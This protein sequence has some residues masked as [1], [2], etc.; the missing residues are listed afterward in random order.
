MTGKLGKHATSLV[1]VLAACGLG[2]YAWRDRATVS[3]DERARRERNVFPAWRR[4]DLSRITLSHD[5]EEVVLVRALAGD[6]MWRMT[7]PRDGE[8][9]AALVDRFL[10]TLEFATILRK[11]SGPVP[12]FDSP[13]ARGT[14]E[15]GAVKYEFALGSAAST[16]EG[17]AYFRMNGDSPVVIGKELAVDLMKGADAF[18]T[19]TLVPYLSLALARLEVRGRVTSFAVERKGNERGFVLPSRSLR[20]SRERLDKVWRA[21]AEMRAE[22]FVSDADADA[23]TK[24]P[25]LSITMT[26]KDGRPNGELLVGGACPGQPNDVVVVQRAPTKTAGCAPKGI[27]EGLSVTEGWLL[28]TRLFALRDDEIEQARL[29]SSPTGAVLD[30]ARKGTGFRELAPE[31]RDLSEGE[32]DAASTLIKDLA[33]AEGEVIGRDASNALGHGIT[34]RV[35]VTHAE[36]GEEEVIEVGLAADEGGFFVRRRADGAVIRVS[37]ETAR[38]LLPRANALRP[39]ALFSEPLAGKPVRA[40]ETRCRGLAQRVSRDGDAFRLEVDGAPLAADSG[41]ILDAI[42]ALSR[43]RADAWVADADDGT[44][45]FDLDPCFFRATFAGSGSDGGGGAAATRTAG[46][47]F[48]ADTIT[49]TYARLDG[50]RAVFVAPQG[51]RAPLTSPFIDRHRLVVDPYSLL[52]IDVTRKGV[53]RT[54]DPHAKDDAGILLG[55]DAAGIL[56]ETVHMGPPRRGEGFEDAV[57]I[58]LRLASDGGKASIRFSLGVA[59]QRGGRP[60]RLLRIPGVDA[61]LAAPAGPDD[62]LARLLGRP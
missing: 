47:T 50:D 16:P 24:D 46:V 31:Q 38:K 8:V 41:M 27:L 35:T 6:G 61:T 12:G 56:T 2:V 18:R 55:E 33:R 13:R 11:S 30:V 29:E 36:A 21:F 28:D 14:I 5:K 39:R 7:A 34:G 10:S 20:V 53:R 52:G 44:F 60:M 9:D 59:V 17:A 26:P 32:S 54:L 1:L 3:V 4:E 23:A 40:I 25:V 15:M 58:V 57:E 45:G 42:D 49:G 62:A 51:L 43:A 22:A 37:A 48:G 19:R